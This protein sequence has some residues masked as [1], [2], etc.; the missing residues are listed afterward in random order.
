MKM[1]DMVSVGHGIVT[2]VL[3][4]IHLLYIFRNFPKLTRIVLWLSKSQ[5][6]FPNVLCNINFYRSSRVDEELNSQNRGV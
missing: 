4:L 5:H 3:F 2:N 6:I 1:Q